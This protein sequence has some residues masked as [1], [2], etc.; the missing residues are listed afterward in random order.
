MATDCATGVPGLSP[1]LFA[2]LSHT[3]D[4][5]GG[6]RMCKQLF[7][8]D[9]TTV[10]VPPALWS[11]KQRG[12]TNVAHG[13]R[14]IGAS[15]VLFVNGR[16]DPY[17][18]VSLLPAQLCKRRARGMTRPRDPPVRAALAPR[19]PAVVAERYTHPSLPPSL[20]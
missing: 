1:S 16:A 9:A 20:L 10:A 13:G 3:D 2:P 14:A 11:G 4:L 6:L 8:I 17:S 19:A 18:S 12:W 15:N 5:S 7:G